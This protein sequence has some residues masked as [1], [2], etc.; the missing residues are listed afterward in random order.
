M[1]KSKFIIV[2][3]LI[4]SFVLNFLG[5]LLLILF[6]AHMNNLV[7]K[8][9]FDLVFYILLG[10]CVSMATAIFW[11]VI[12]KVINYNVQGVLVP[13]KLGTLN[14][15]YFHRYQI[16]PTIFLFKKILFNLLKSI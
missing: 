9:V 10:V 3:V 14:F 4:M 11:Y 8:W 5:L 1:Q 7:S 6:A 12:K 13:Y 2:I 16:S 15:R